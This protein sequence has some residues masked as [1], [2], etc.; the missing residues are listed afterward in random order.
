MIDG[1]LVLV[2]YSNWEEEG[3][4]DSGEGEGGCKGLKLNFCFQALGL[5]N[6][7]RALGGLINR[8]GGLLP[9]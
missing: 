7:Q 4:R 9:D 3:T 8:R 6:F 5:F 2:I 1:V